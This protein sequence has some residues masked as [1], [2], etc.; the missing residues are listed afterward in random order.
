MFFACLSSRCFGNTAL[1]LAYVARGSVD[2]FQ[3]EY[4]K[5][6]DVAAGV[7]LIQEAGGK[8]YNTNGEK[9]SLMEANLA[10]AGTEKLCQQLLVSISEADKS[11][12][13]FQ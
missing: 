4:I 7:L 2:C 13:L 12:L 11:T 9:F 1:T 6:W 10:C 8:V 3:I 5:P